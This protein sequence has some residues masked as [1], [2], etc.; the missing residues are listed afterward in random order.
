MKWKADFQTDKARTARCADMVAS[1]D[2][3]WLLKAAW[4]HFTWSV[5]AGEMSTRIEGARDF[6]SVLEGIVEPG[7]GTPKVQQNLEVEP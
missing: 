2:F 4:G 6:V 3:Q 1:E 5:K 7:R